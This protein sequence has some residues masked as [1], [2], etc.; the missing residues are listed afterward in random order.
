MERKVKARAH[1]GNYSR[2]E[3]I[4]QAPIRSY[5]NTTYSSGRKSIYWGTIKVEQGKKIGIW[6]S[7]GTFRIVEGPKKESAY[8]SEYIELKHHT[9]APE[10]YMDIEYLNGKK[11]VQPGPYDLWFDPSRHKN[12]SVAKKVTVDKNECIIIY[13]ETD[14]GVKRKII[15]GPKL[16][17]PEPKS[18]IHKFSWKND[19]TTA[20]FYKLRTTPDTMDI[21]VEYVRTADDALLNVNLRVF[22]QIANV[23]KMIDA[24]QDPISDL[25]NAVA[26]DVIQAVAKTI[27]IKFK[28][29][30]EAFNDLKTYKETREMAKRIGYDLN[31][32]V[33]KG[34]QA[35]QALQKMVDEGIARRAQ[36]ALDAD[37]DKQHQQMLDFKVS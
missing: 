11:E 18:W 36:L 32:V 20:S 22:F 2:A 37:K 27:F 16:Y 34:F 31:K 25:S 33:F 14:E 35:G 28:G 17:I 5:S 21:D 10:E 6:D 19:E 8:K 3:T 15:D 1:W 12:M 13:Y 26:T 24:T 23:K 7:E 9:A 30:T 29:T 4:Q